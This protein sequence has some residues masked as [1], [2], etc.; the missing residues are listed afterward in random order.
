MRHEFYVDLSH[1]NEANLINECRHAIVVKLTP[2]IF[3]S[4][5][6][7]NYNAVPNW[8]AYG[9]YVVGLYFETQADYM[10]FK[11]NWSLS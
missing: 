3:E 9:D 1:N 2:E 7:N 4:W 6:K 10:F 8:Q 5:L 11:L